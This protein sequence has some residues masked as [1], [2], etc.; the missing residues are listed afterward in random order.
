VLTSLRQA[1]DTARTTLVQAEA[2][3]KTADGTIGPD[4][5]LRY[6]LARMIKELTD[7]ARSLRSLADYIEQ[8]PNA[9]VF[10]KS[11]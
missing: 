10:G 6:D 2:T 4:S 11:R 5:A 8:N 9:L 1:S 3:L 7:T